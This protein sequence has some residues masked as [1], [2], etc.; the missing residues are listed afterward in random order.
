M[1]VGKVPQG[2]VSIELGGLDGKIIFPF[3]EKHT[4]E[5]PNET[6]GRQ[7]GVVNPGVPPIPLIIEKCSEPIL[8]LS[9]FIL[10][11]CD[12]PIRIESIDITVMSGETEAQFKNPFRVSPTFK[13][14]SYSNVSGIHWSRQ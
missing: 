8:V 9:K 5:L 11:L 12:V 2:V 10:L 13:V 7:K 6:G 3:T 14:K 1:P 4:S